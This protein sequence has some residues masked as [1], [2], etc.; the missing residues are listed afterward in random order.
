MH[1]LTSRAARLPRAPP[2]AVRP[3]VGYAAARAVRRWSTDIGLH[4]V[5]LLDFDPAI[6]SAA[7]GGAR[8]DVEI[9]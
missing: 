7:D 3:P 2:E 4:P 9:H 8:E 6:N 1:V 5:L